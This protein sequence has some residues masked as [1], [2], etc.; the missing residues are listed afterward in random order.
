MEKFTSIAGS[1]YTRVM[2][3]HIEFP[4]AALGNFSFKNMTLTCPYWPPKF[5]WGR[6][7][8]SQIFPTNLCWRVLHLS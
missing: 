1:N 5:V 2:L 7:N 8:I 6:V 3:N 4:F